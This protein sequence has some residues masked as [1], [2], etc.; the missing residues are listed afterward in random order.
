MSDNKTVATIPARNALQAIPVPNYSFE[1]I[2]RMATSFAKSG[3]FGVKDADS[4]FSLMMYSQAIGK[5][6][7][8][9]MMDYDLIKGRLSKKSGSMLR[10]FQL[11]G[12]RVEWESL[13]DDC[14]SAFFS[15][16]LSPKP[17]KIDWTLE[18]AKKAGLVGREGDMYG[19]YTRAMLRSRCISEGIRSTAP[20]A[21]EQMYTPE[22]VRDMEEPTPEPVSITAAVAGAAEQVTH[23]LDKEEVDAMIDSL[24]VDSMAALTTAFGKAY[25]R[26]KEAKDEDAKR[27]LKS[28]YDMMKSVLEPMEKLVPGDDND[29]SEVV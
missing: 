16:P 9:I 21:T 14:A 5:H 11:S 13:T 26:A 1:Q 20:E 27:R 22:E 15:H 23:A 3:L 7:A 19:K 17:I 6:P 24:D 18:R 28:S 2:Q 12:G 29:S 4:A 25:T 8:I 10:D